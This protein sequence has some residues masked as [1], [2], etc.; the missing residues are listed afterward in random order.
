M[1][2]AIGTIDQTVNVVRRRQ[3]LW[4]GCILCV[5]IPGC[6]PARA[7]PVEADLARQTLYE[8][9]EHWKQGG[10]ID[11]LRQVTPQVVVQERLWSEGNKL[12]DYAITDD[13]RKEDANWYCEVELT[14]QPPEGGE[15][16]KKK[17]T[18]VVGTDPVLRGNESQQDLPDGE[19]ISDYSPTR[20]GKSR[21]DWKWLAERFDKNGDGRIARSEVPLAR[22]DFNRLDQTWD[23]AL[24]DA[25]FEWSPDGQLCRQKETTFALFKSVDANSD[26]RLS[27]QE[28]QALIE[29]QTGEKGYLDERDLEKL[30]FLPRVL[31]TRAEYKSRASHVT[32]QMDD[33]GRLPTNLPEPGA[34]AP[35]FELKS[36]DGDHL[37]RLS[38]FRGQ[39]P[40]VLVFGCLT[41]G[42]YRTYSEP[43]EAMYRQWKDQV[44]FLRVYVR[45]AHPSDT[46]APTGTN[47]RANILVKQPRTFDERCTVARRF[48]TEMQIETPM[49]VDEIDNRVGQA[50]GGWPDRLYLIDRDGRVVYQGG[51]GPFAFNPRELEQSLLMMLLDQNAPTPDTK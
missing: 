6:G 27:P 23:G 38:S 37:V 29:K 11:E 49:V 9:L 20:T 34:L 41:C 1:Q 35:D 40:V 32:F 48:S 51:P 47:A 2:S 14:L 3:A 19:D 18:Y 46:H 13:G 45:E 17:V 7:R 16:V 5:A 44:E 4:L 31:K 8:V 24:T 10:E 39:K 30:I 26:G 28:L 15:P 25:D 42:N 33:Q 43:L 12:L 36:P 22:E 50:Y 21:Y